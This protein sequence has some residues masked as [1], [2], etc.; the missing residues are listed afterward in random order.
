[1]GEKTKFIIMAVLAAVLAASLL[2]NL[3]TLGSKK[4]MEEEL[5]YVK[6]ENTTLNKKIDEGRK[7]KK[8]LEEKV[9]AL[10]A[11]LTKFTAEKE[12]LLKQRDEL[13]KQYE[14]LLQEKN[15]L[16]EKLSA[17]PDA[18]PVD[19]SLAAPK[20]DN[21]YWAN[22]LKAKADLELQLKTLQSSSAELERNKI[23]LEVTLDN[24]TNEKKELEQQLAYHKKIVDD[25]AT[26]LVRDK[27]ERLMLQERV[28]A[29][30]EENKTLRRQLTSLSNSKLKLEKKLSSL[31]EEKTQFERKLA[32][33]ELY[34][35]EKL[36]SVNDIKQQLEVVRGAGAAQ[37]SPS[38][39]DSVELP[40]IVVRPPSEI[41]LPAQKGR[42]SGQV[43]LE[44]GSILSVNRE[45]NFVIIDLGK[46]AGVEVG[47]V[48]N[49]YGPTDEVIATI[50]VIQNRKTISACDI[51]EER[52]PMQVGD[53]VKRA[54]E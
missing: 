13:Q 10:N 6:N 24:M 8:A 12:E 49:V 39:R 19:V 31:E 34:L 53:K 3:N 45:S 41:P 29:L 4:A 38:A 23:G 44:G 35:N 43:T 33:M 48:F 1:M 9:T 17:K 20:T 2:I 18:A 52:A 5:K 46:D 36:A 26:E 14:V 11:D 30:K 7:E 22:V 21:E 32:Q 47:D 50:E 15:K 42:E 51:R 40:P 25:M 54:E 37:V 27:N 16:S 28:T